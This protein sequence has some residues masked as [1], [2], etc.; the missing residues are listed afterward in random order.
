MKQD[1][2]IVGGGI[3]G[4]ATA[5]AL[6]SRLPQAKITLLEK[7]SAVAGHQTGRNS[8]VIHSGV[9]YNPGS[10]KARL[11]VEGRRRL[12][13]FCEQYGLPVEMC[14]KLIV[15]THSEQMRKI[16]DLARRGEKNG[17]EGLKIL[18]ASAMR[19]KEP[20]VAGLSA[21]W[22]PSAGITD[23]RKISRTLSECLR[24]DG[25]HLEFDSEVRRLSRRADG[26]QIATKQKEF[27]SRQLIVCGGIHGHRIAGRAGIRPNIKLLP[28]R[29][30]YFR[31]IPQSVGKVRGLIYPAPDSRV[32]FLGVH[33]TRTIYGGVLAGPNAVL[34]LSKEGYRKHQV[35]PADMLE[36]VTYGGFWR[37]ARQYWRIGLS[38]SLR[39]LSKAR[40]LE[41]LRLLLPDL[42]AT[43]LKPAQ[44]GIRAQ[45][46]TEQGRLADDFYL[47]TDNGACFV[48]N[49]PSPAATSSLAVGSYVVDQVLGGGAGA[50][51]RKKLV[52][53]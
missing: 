47:H 16:E 9:Y 14:G 5:Q 27:A 26:W 32:P 45:A 29:G 20:Y 6:R 50:V 17:V 7:E 13:E 15:A 42:T 39:S 8:G 3:V 24:R 10:L 37:F 43:E 51:G 48:L 44:S 2:V 34:A 23:F 21:L 18:D 28:F 41:D 25:V 36:W 11:C 46:V 12:L 31:L 53:T 22:V 40:F 33:L 4:L 38:E 30:E 35:S 49:V 1:F 52:K 19:S